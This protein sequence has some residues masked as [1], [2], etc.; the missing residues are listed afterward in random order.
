MKKIIFLLS[1]FP[2]IAMGTTIDIHDTNFTGALTAGFVFK[3]NDHVFKEVYGV[4]IA[5]AITADGCYRFWKHWAMGAKIS[6]W[7]IHGHT[8][9][10]KRS[11]FIQEVPITAYVRGIYDLRCNLQLYASLGGGAI[12]LHEKSYLGKISFWKGIGEAEIGFNYPVWHCMTI[13]SAF[14]YLFPRQSHCGS[15]KI[16]VGGFDLRAGLGFVY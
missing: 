16:D 7:L 15:C 2:T 6:Y 13:T 14:R 11:S 10:F 9:L 4:G 5:N 8:T 12:W 1:L 3:H